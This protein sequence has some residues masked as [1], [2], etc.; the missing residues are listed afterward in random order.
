MKNE[1][2]RRILVIRLSSMGDI[3]L[4]SALINLIRETF[5]LAR[6]D[7]CTKEQFAYLARS[8]PNIH[9]VIKAK[10]EITREALKELKELIKLNNYNLIV[11]AQNN[12]NSLYLRSSQD[13]QKLVFRKHSIRKFLLVNFKINLLKNF[14]PIINRYKQILSKFA[15]IEKIN[16]IETPE[17]FTDEVSERSIEKMLESLSIAQGTE[18]VCIPAVSKHFTKTYPAENY[19]EIINNYPNSQAVFFFTG[20]GSDSTNI[21]TIK[22]LTKE[23]KVYDLCDK[24][25]IPDLISLIKR[26]SLVICGDTGPMHIAEA[27]DIPVIMLAGSSVNEFGFYPQN[28]SS[29][30]LENN[31]LKCRPCSHIGRSSCPK[32]HFKCMVEIT[33]GMVLDKANELT[34]P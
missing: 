4:T 17:V 12:F 2:V 32:G 14:P 34:L 7:Y 29:V 10:N 18:I 13:A 5:P 31:T 16:Q 9:K 26:C 22:S 11:D 3:I 20:T 25:E 28:E 30:V 19:A 23:R 8:N 1:Q 6:I 33:T 15:A 27:L 21:N 24:L